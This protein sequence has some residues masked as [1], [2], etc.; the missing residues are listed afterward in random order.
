[1]SHGEPLGLATPKPWVRRAIGVLGVLFLAS[2]VWTAMGPAETQRSAALAAFAGLLLW[3]LLHQLLQLGAARDALAASQQRFALAVAGSDD[4]IWD[5]D[6]AA[7]RIYLSARARE[8]LGVPDAPEVG[9]KEEIFRQVRMHPDD[10]AQ[11]EQALLEHFAGR[12]PAFDGEYRVLHDDGS[13]RWIH[14]RGV[15]VRDDEGNPLRI[16][17]SISDIDARKRAEH[18]LRQSE[19]RYAI[20]MIGMN[21]AHWVWDVATDDVF[22][23]PN[24]AAMVG[25]APAALPTKGRDWLVAVPLH[26][27]D[28]RLLIDAV[29][30]HLAGRTARIDVEYRVLDRGTGSYRWVQTRGQL[31]RDAQGR[32]QRVAG[33]TV[34][35]SERKRTQE[36]LRQ[37]EQALR[38]SEER[39]QLAVDGANEGLWDWDLPSD[40][41]FLSPRAQEALSLGPSEPRRLRREWIALATYHPD[42]VPAVREALSAHL[43]GETQTF[44]VEYRLRHRDGNWH[45]Y[46]QHGVALRDANGRAYRMAGSMEDV[47]DRKNAQAERERLEQRLRQAQKLEAMGTLAGGIAHDF[48]NILAAILGYGEMAQ[49]EAPEGTELR[50]HID[51]TIS[52]GMRAKSLVER[53]LAFSRSGMGQSVPVHVQSVVA[54]ALDQ[55][56]AS[57]PTGVRLERRL[58]AGDAAVLG[59]AT[60]I[61]QVVM[62]LCANAVQAVGA[63]GTVCVRVDTVELDAP[64]CLTTNELAPGAYVRLL[65]ADTGVGIEPR[66]LER[67]FD[68]FF[69][70]RDIGV[71]TGLGLSLVHGIVTDLGGGIEVASCCGEGTTMTVYLPRQASASLPVAVEEEPVAQGNGQTVLIVDDEVPLVRLGEELLAQ[72]GYEPVGFASSVQALDCF[73]SEPQRFDLVLSDEAMPGMTGSEL[74]QQIRAIRPDIPIVLMSGYVS[75]AL[76]ARAKELDVV[77]ILGKPLASREIARS[78]AGALRATA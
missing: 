11:R 20:A 2:M 24:L 6:L 41:L 44:D 22:A 47:T 23:S 16:A 8:L 27:D 31:F 17:G 39:Y 51:A 56:N 61:H 38:E 26:P 25:L 13:A 75:A 67:I 55:V 3:L 4:G 15:C 69:T 42:D 18:A 5:W 37:S 34:D 49:K 28:R 52:A 68:P 21:V 66:L 46:R 33:A 62:N 19:E 64:R 14:V 73:R 48:N 57:L 1:M 65:V 50:R 29:D 9:S 70:T 36:A 71:G 10:A 45:W 12:S 40:M 78:L 43:Q 7:Q 35:V 77:E 63:E 54:E 60:Q 72:L 74:A 32:A 58:E 59:D 30:E 53:I 76:S